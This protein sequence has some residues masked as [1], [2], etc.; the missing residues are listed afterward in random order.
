MNTSS[1]ITVNDFWTAHEHGCAPVTEAV[2]A[3]LTARGM[4]LGCLGERILVDVSAEHELTDEQMHIAVEAWRDAMRDAHLETAMAFAV[5]SEFADA[6]TYFVAT[7]EHGNVPL[8]NFEVGAMF[9]SLSDRDFAHVLFP[10]TEA[11]LERLVDELGFGDE[12][13][14]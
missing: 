1:T 13:L 14:S 11:A 4:C 10:S 3:Q 9:A 7:G 8:D 5:S 2:F 12:V 6:A